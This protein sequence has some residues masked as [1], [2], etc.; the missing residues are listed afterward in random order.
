[1]LNGF[2]ALVQ[3]CEEAKYIL[4]KI[5]IFNFSFFQI[6]RC[7]HLVICNYFGDMSMKACGTMCDVC[8]QHEL[9]STNLQNLKVN[10]QLNFSRIELNFLEKE[11][12]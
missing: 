9:I 4:N 10:F 6:S 2:N 8:T 1:M 7:R 5:L 11:I 3:Y 12:R